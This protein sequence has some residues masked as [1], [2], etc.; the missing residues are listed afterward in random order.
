MNSNEN[1]LQEVKHVRILKFRKSVSKKD[2]KKWLIEKRGENWKEKQ[3]YGQFIR[4]MP[5]DT[6]KEKFSSG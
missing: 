3:R 4:D 1:L 6:D 5:E 2:F